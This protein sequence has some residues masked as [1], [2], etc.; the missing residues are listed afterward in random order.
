M[1]F[2]SVAAFLILTAGTRAPNKTDAACCSAATAKAPVKVVKVEGY[3]CPL[4]GEVLPCP[5]C[6]PANAKAAK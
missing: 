6:C 5:N 2:G 3:I 1:G 4:T